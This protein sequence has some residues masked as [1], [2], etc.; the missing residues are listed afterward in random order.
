MISIIS[1][2]TVLTRLLSGR[3]L[4]IRMLAWKSK[5]YFHLLGGLLALD[6]MSARSIVQHRISPSSEKDQMMPLLEYPILYL[7]NTAP[8][9]ANSARIQIEDPT[10]FHAQAA[11]MVGAFPL[12]LQTNASFISATGSSFGLSA[13]SNA[14]ANSLIS[15]GDDTDAVG[16]SQPSKAQAVNSV[17]GGRGTS[18]HPAGL[19]PSAGGS[20]PSEKQCAKSCPQHCF[21][22]SNEALFQTFFNEFVNMKD[23][24]EH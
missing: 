17:G 8:R 14:A 3:K 11:G 13:S 15:S 9:Q 5:M 20:A 16:A 18:E 23:R 6:S 2:N 12:S 4:G 7:R 24:F 1:L 10:L 22:S 19:E 21:T